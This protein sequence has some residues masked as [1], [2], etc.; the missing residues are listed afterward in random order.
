[1]L[2]LPRLL[3]RN[4]APTTRPSGSTHRRLRAATRLAGQRLDL[5]DVGAEAS[6]QLRGVRQRLHLLRG[7][8]ADAVEGLAVLRRALRSRRRR[9]SAQSAWLGAE[10]RHERHHLARVAAEVVRERE[11]AV[12]AESRAARAPRPAAA[13]ST[14]TSSAAPTRRRDGRSSSARRRGSPADRR[15]GRTCPRG[16]PSTPYPARRSPRS[17]INTISVGVKQSCTS[18]IASCARGSV[19]P[20]CRYASSALSTTSGNV[21]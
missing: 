3:R 5:D 13:A 16:S 8:D 18:A 17:S 11:L 1:M 20:A 15:R 10:D 2:R 12:V 9:P 4:V 19:M 14:R 21:V 6:Q 7:E